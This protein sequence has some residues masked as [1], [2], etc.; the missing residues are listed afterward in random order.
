MKKDKHVKTT[1]GN[2]EIWEHEIGVHNDL[3]EQK[4]A[5]RIFIKA[6]SQN[7]FKVHSSAKDLEDYIA[8]LN[9]IIPVK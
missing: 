2:L 5:S 4:Y 8:G 9:L 3:I 1:Q 6:R 7:V